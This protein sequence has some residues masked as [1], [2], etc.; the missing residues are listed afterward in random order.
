MGQV[1]EELH[2]APALAA[3]AREAGVDLPITD[4]VCGVIGGTPIPEVL[5]TLLARAAPAGEF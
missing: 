3:L 5:A 4:A 2:T 1:V